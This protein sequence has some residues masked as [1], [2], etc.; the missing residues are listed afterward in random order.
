MLQ[1][2]ERSFGDFAAQDHSRGNQSHPFILKMA[3]VCHPCASTEMDSVAVD[4]GK[5]G[6]TS[7]TEG[8]HGQVDSSSP[9][10]CGSVADDRAWLERMDPYEPLREPARGR[11]SPDD[12]GEAEGVRHP[13]SQPSVST[14]TG[15]DSCTAN[16]DTEDSSA[17]E[18]DSRPSI[19]L[20]ISTSR[21]VETI[22]SP[23]HDS[24]WAAN[25]TVAEPS[26]CS[27]GGHEDRPRSTPVDLANNKRIPTSIV[28]PKTETVL[29]PLG[30]MTP[31]NRSLPQ[32]QGNA[33]SSK[34]TSSMTAHSNE[35]SLKHM[36][37]GQLDKEELS[38]HQTS[39]TMSAKKP[40][41]DDS[42]DDVPFQQRSQFKAKMGSR[43]VMLDESEESTVDDGELSGTEAE[44]SSECVDSNARSY[45]GAESTST[46]GE[47]SVA[48][49]IHT[50]DGLHIEG[51]PLPLHGAG[52]GTFASCDKQS[53][54]ASQAGSTAPISLNKKFA[55][56]LSTGSHFTG[57]NEPACSQSERV[58]RMDGGLALEL[59][60]I[61]SP[62]AS[63]ACQSPRVIDLL[64]SSDDSD[65]S[66]EYEAPLTSRKPSASTKMSTRK[67]SQ[68]VIELLSSSS[69]SED[70][71]DSED[72]S[73]R[74]SPSTSKYSAGSF[75]S[76]DDEPGEYAGPEVRRP[77]NNKSLQ[78]PVRLSQSPASKR[79]FLRQRNSIAQRLFLEYDR[80]VFK[81]ALSTGGACTL[82]WSK[83]LITTAGLTEMPKGSKTATVTLSTKLIDRE[84]R[85]RLTLMHEL[86]HAASWIID[87]CS[88]PPHGEVFRKWGA[89]AERLV[90]GMKVSTTHDYKIEYKYSWKCQNS[91]CGKVYG[92]TR[93]VIDVKRH[94][95]GDC[96]SQLVELLKPATAKPKAPPSEYQRF[97]QEHSASVRRQL[98]AAAA[99]VL[100][101]SAL[102]GNQA[103]VSSAA[104]TKVSQS[105]VMKECARLWQA[106]KAESK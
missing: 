57:S 36:P 103:V 98:E 13:E 72:E 49:L 102:A 15:E 95:C 32:P 18:E 10:R 45:R 71:F 90:P 82:K 105:E 46:T 21:S 42:D 70:E 22:M 62:G 87:G 81:G 74:H 63:V 93:R 96:K 38:P 30:S 6:C 84:S 26:I 83:R 75:T 85:L 97:V 34:H 44:P 78:A 99:N 16:E 5:V 31:Y 73:T 60:N 35:A 56:E 91:E 79:A 100:G 53:D 54:V 89:R 40:W 25:T 14:R 88:K 3:Q 33:N 20:L 76:S 23:M 59:V 80:I 67:P 55:R 101:P 69:D 58:S 68:K 9:I 64:D 50:M 24:A 12:G 28:R 65:E 8:L 2:E 48:N 4:T 37:R 19:P 92:R 94:R 7:G 11:G 47:V 61:E 41:D 66:E 51:G 29:S 43:R 104:T 27:S 52:D 86:C 77:V 106:Q 39:T 17:C 1:E